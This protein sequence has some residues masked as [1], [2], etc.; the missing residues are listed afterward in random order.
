MEKKAVT[1]SE[2]DKKMKLHR[3]WVEK[4]KGG[5]KASFPES[6]STRSLTC[7]AWT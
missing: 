1:K 6:I 4:R 7:P 2:F 3:L 5:E